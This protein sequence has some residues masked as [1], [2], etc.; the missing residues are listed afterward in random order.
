MGMDNSAADIFVIGDDPSLGVNDALRITAASP[1][2]TS[3]NTTHPTGTFDYVCAEC[4]DHS[5]S[6]FYCHGE[7]AKWHDDVVAF[8]SMV[9]RDE[10]GINQMVKMGVMYRS[11][12]NYG[13]QQVFTNLGAD[14][15]FVGAMAFQNRERMD[16][17]NEAI[18]ARLKR[19]EQ[20]LGA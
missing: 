9:L 13:E 3:Y 15:L 5:D 6:P 2:V 4:G 7:H 10:D 19:I 18:D 14:F 8:R 17:Q 1:P 11:E 12:N 16:A 20:A